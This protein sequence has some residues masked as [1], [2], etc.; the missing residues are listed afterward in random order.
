MKKVR[1][2]IIP[3]ADILCYCLMP[4]HFHFL[5]RPKPEGCLPSPSKKVWSGSSKEQQYQ[6]MLS[7]QIK[8]LLS[9]YTKAFNRRYNR[10]GSLFQAKTKA[11]PGYE[12]FLPEGFELVDEI[13]FTQFMPYLQNCFHYIHNNPVVA[14]YA[15]IATD[16]E[17]SSAVDYAGL[18]DGTLC[19]YALTEQL[20]GIKRTQ[21]NP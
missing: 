8:T 11:K 3:Y 7:H 2:H 17:Y 5:L 16:W 21:P 12:D 15:L 6:Q 4:D 19:N 10:R 14:H 9:S 18:R 20:L 13:P 1:T